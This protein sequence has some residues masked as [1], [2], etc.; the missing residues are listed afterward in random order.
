MKEKLKDALQEAIEIHKQMM[1]LSSETLT[2]SEDNMCIEKI[3]LNVDI[4]NSEMKEY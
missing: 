3:K 1:E 2:G 4:S